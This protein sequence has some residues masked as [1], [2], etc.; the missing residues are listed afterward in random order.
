MLGPESLSAIRHAAAVGARSL[1]VPPL[2]RLTRRLGW[3][4]FNAR[5]GSAASLMP[6]G[7][8]VMGCAGLA[9]SVRRGS[10]SLRAAHELLDAARSRGCATFDTAAVYGEGASERMLGSW[11][12][13]RRLRDEVVIVTKGGHPL[14]YGGSRLSP[15]D[16]TA[17]LDAS[18]ERLG[19]DRI[20]LYML[21]RDDAD[22]DVGPVMETLHAFVQAGKVLSIGASNWTPQR[23]E[24]ANHYAVTRGLTPFTAS[25]PHLSLAEMYRPPWPGCVSISGADNADARAWYEHTQMPVLAWSPLSGGYLA[26]GG[27]RDTDQ[28]EAYDGP[29]NAERRARLRT[30]AE[31]RGAKPEELAVA[32]VRHLGMNV[33]PVVA[34]ASPDRLA[35]LIDATSL[36]LALDEVAWLDLQS[37]DDPSQMGVR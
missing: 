37:D 29:A 9:G 5:A 24:L 35:A 4:P 25:S 16:L 17:D 3:Q 20:D 21:H 33:V 34:S 18:L 1:A 28:M 14:P 31:R 10:A 30:L 23:I 13:S 27:A 2:M 6:L 36:E 11:I 7:S 15:A 8:V 22:V 26:A 32:F 19:T 12:R